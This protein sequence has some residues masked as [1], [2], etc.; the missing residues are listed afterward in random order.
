MAS[1]VFRFAMI[2]A[3]KTPD[4]SASAT[5]TVPLEDDKGTPLV[6][7]LR[8]AQQGGSPAEMIKLATAY[9]AT[10]DFIDSASKVADPY[11]QLALAVRGNAS[12]PAD[13]YFKQA[14]TQI[15][16]QDAA[17][18]VGTPAFQKLRTQLNDSLV[19]SIMLVDQ[20]PRTK[21]LILYLR[22]ALFLAEQ[23]AADKLTSQ[24]V[25]DLRILLPSGLF[26]LPASGQSLADERAAQR[27]QTDALNAERAKQL[28]ALAAQLSDQR[29]AVNELVRAF[30]LLDVS[31]AKPAS[32][33]AGAASAAAPH[34]AAA[35]SAGGSSS[36]VVA[37]PGS[38]VSAK[39]V[40]FVLPAE[41]TGKLSAATKH[42]L[43]KLGVLETEVDVA[44]AVGM[45]EASNAGIAAALHAD[46]GLG[47]AM[48][49]VGSK[50]LPTNFIAPSRA[51]DIGPVWPGV[52]LSMGPCPPAA[53]DTAPST[54]NP[55][56]FSGH[57]EA[58]ILGI[59]DLMVVEQELARYELGEISHIE[60]VLQSELRE[61]KLMTS[62]ITDVTNLTETEVTDQ[63]TQDLQSTDRFELQTEAQ[64]V[65]T[66]DTSKEDGVTLTASYGPVSLTAN[67]NATSNT[68]TQDSRQASSSYARDTTSRAVSSL[69]KR[70]LQRQIVRTINKIT[71]HNKHSFDNSQG[72]H[73][74]TGI[75][76]WLNKVY[77]AQ[78]V[79]YGQRLMLEFIVPEPAAFLRYAMTHT[80]VGDITLINPDPPGY[81]I[82][83]QTFQPLRVQDITRDS[84][85][86]WV[87]KY[88]VQ[89]V[90][91]PPAP[92]NIASA[93]MVDNGDSLKDGTLDDGTA[94]GVAVKFASAKFDVP[95]TE[96]YIPY[97]AGINLH[98]VQAKTA[99]LTVQ[100]QDQEVAND[101]IGGFGRVTLSATA[102]ASIPVTVNSINFYNYEIIVDVL[103]TLSP[104][105]FG[106]W[107]LATFKSIMNAY[108]DLKANYDNAVQAAK[109]R[110]GFNQIQGKNPIANRETEQ[111]ELKRGC[112]SLLSGQRFETFDAM[113]PNVAPYGYPE[114]DFTEA[115][116]DGQVILFFEQAFEWTNMTYVF[117]PYFWS[118]KQEWVML[119]QLDDDDPLFAKFLQ[120]GA[121][122]V[123][124]PVRIGFQQ[125]ML[126][127]LKLGFQW[128]ADGTLVIADED[129]Q[130]DPVQMSIIDELKSQSGNNAIDGPGT[131]NVTNNSA[132]VTGAGT[133]FSAA[134]VNRRIIIK[135]VTY[136][137]K[138]VASATSIALS[139]SYQAASDTDLQYALG[140]VLVGQ[141]WE[142]VLPTDLIKIDAATG[143]IG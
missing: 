26:P 23:L 137:I 129:G 7:N 127:Y 29:N 57:G 46:V 123:Q 131:I 64:N 27:K 67:Y 41:T 61:H 140:G 19:A 98:G 59:A 113:V 17:A 48:V 107:Q 47:Q 82:G 132:T 11:R 70:T 108:N 135:G 86:S 21:S 109:V 18:V 4:G 49:Q 141:S 5:T 83:G 94:N 6:N 68:A 42:V 14:F 130:P 35:S 40:P 110:A 89:D 102:T 78:I 96:G 118:N 121:A 114:I 53:I 16:G 12:R 62:Q 52:S 88:G 133:E 22:Y 71:E 106:E 72:T 116:A 143:L 39:R 1:E 45:L 58:R 115:K 33:S 74:I 81:C 13:S 44:K 66:S 97:T 111:I 112:I 139:T 120:A 54:T 85:L 119:S 63:K 20:P 51:I 55:T 91:P 90:N 9:S 69:E 142:I 84:Y 34:L 31:A 128:T 117:Y 8:K 10:A 28:Q 30:E 50:F 136:V 99:Y 43:T 87:S 37:P 3:P 125:A 104:E 76:R 126:H 79:N 122:R 56:V 124:V 36:V 93:S 25:L 60:N 24:S 138:S 100:I 92:L 134:D 65:I 38:T 2:R 80:P 73:D 101:T 103:C 15:F 77:K 32:G 75:Y 95:I 105:K